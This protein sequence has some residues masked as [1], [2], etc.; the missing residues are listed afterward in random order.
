MGSNK[1]YSI[2]LPP[3]LAK[4]AAALAK[5]ESRTVSEVM[6]EAL[7]HYQR[8]QL[9]LSDVREY[10]RLLTPPPPAYRAIREDARRKGSDKLT[11]LEIDREIAATRRERAGKNATRGRT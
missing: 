2:T 9:K 6:R 8:R 10:I 4:Q 11:A 3:E 1:V 5:K 7:R